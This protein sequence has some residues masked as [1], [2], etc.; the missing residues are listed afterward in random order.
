[1][2]P[3]SCS[4]IVRPKLFELPNMDPYFSATRPYYKI[5]PKLQ[6][7][8][9][10][11][12]LPKILK[13][14]KEFVLRILAGNVHRRWMICW[15][16]ILL[17]NKAF[18]IKL[19]IIQLKHKNITIIRTVIKIIE[20]DVK[21]FSCNVLKGPPLWSTGQSFWLQIQRSR[22]RFPTLPDFLRN[23]SFGTGTTQLREDNWG[24]TWMKI[25]ASI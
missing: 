3:S 11:I 21:I 12:N 14:Y 9:Y 6:C 18:G 16:Y 13:V 8:D 23:R 20:Y 2:G 22:V 4:I 10:N 15:K 24:A 5:M 1:M 25:A 7:K 19:K 17:R